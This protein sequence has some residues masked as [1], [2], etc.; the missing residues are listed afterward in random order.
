[1]KRKVYSD[2]PSF[3]ADNAAT[4]ADLPFS[5][6]I[7]VLGES[8][9]VGTKT[10]P[11]R[12]ACQAME[13]CDGDADGR[14]GE[15]TGRRYRR[16]A[17]GG[18]GIIWFEATAVM[19]EGRANPRQLY[20]TEEDLDSFKKQVEEIK[21]TALR[22]RGHEPLVIMQATHSGRYSKPDGTP[23]PII[24]KHD[25]LLEKDTPVDDGRIASDE[26]LDRVGEALVN[27][28][29]LAERA[30]F[31]GVD[32]KSC[33]R[34]L[35]SELLSA[36]DRPGRYGGP[37]E[38]RTR[39]LRESVKGAFAA[40]GTGFIVTSRLNV[41]D[42]MPYPSGFGVTGDG[43]FD[44][45]EPSLLVKEL[46]GL[47]VKLLDM[48]MGN[49][50]FNPHVNRPFALGPYEPEE[51]PLL[52]VKRVLDGTSQIKKAAPGTALICSAISYLGVAAPG[53]VSAY[54]RDGGFDVA[55][56]GR[57]AIA[58]PDFAKDILDSGE[59]DGRKICLCCSKC[60]EIM[61]KPGGTPGCAVRDREVYL[62]VYREL[63]GR[64]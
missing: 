61:R 29:V 42:G 16:F 3:L 14:P 53:V 58:Y 9:S 7:S 23:A 48:T 28:A 26:Y 45:A 54:I 37:F 2:V 49:P 51:H 5:A 18:A 60:T 17:A 32:I 63:C 39:L 22:E 46:A 59:M 40:T 44:P 55:G 34:Y 19:R 30:G 1:M 24:V 47:G 41:C 56:F 33:H 36:Y 10:A 35:L 15:L 20:I 57:E 21:E 8:L 6:D 27:G 12:L 31:D 64:E 50:Y 43:S 4:G 11:N 52:G 62:P 13:G 25:P 38:N